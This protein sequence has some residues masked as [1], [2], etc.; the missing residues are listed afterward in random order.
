MLTSEFV[1]AVKR[2]A[3]VPTSQSTFQQTDFYS[4]ADEETR[5]KMIPLILRTLEEFFVQNFN[6]NITANQANYAI[7]TR[8]IAN[9]LRNVQIVDQQNDLNR[10]DIPR[11]APEDLFSSFSGNYRFNVQKS[12]FYLEGPNVVLY[13]TPTSTANLL[14]LAYYCR[15]NSLVDTTACALVTSVNTGANQITVSALPTTFTTASPLD[16]IQ[17]NSPFSWAAQDQ[18]PTNISGTTLTFG[19]TL[20]TNIA[21]GDYLCLSGQTCVLQIPLELQPLLVQYVVVR[22]LAAQGDAQALQAAMAE[23]GVLEQNAM[24][25]I[26]PRVVGKTK[27]VANGRGINRFV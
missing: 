14:R 24:L 1:V 16:F 19:S 13:P 4:L 26:S 22:V 7:P 15:P 11:L 10:A 9:A 27:R 3:A 5:S 23:L 8:A 12:G 25:L 18:T 17:A 20:P 6:Y 21:A 2:R